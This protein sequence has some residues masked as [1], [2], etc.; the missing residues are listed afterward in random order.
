MIKASL[1]LFHS[2]R[3]NCATGFTAFGSYSGRV[4]P[5]GIHNLS[6]AF[7]LLP[8]SKIWTILQSSHLALGAGSLLVSVEFRFF[9]ISATGSQKIFIL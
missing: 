1:P 5:P 4:R 8:K 2:R 9:E 7:E 3:G 6:S